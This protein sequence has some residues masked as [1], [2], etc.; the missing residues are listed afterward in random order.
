[1]KLT[2]RIKRTVPAVLMM[3]AMSMTSFAGSWQATAEGWK[4]LNDYGTYTANTWMVA[5][6]L[7]YHMN[8]F[9]IMDTGWIQDSADGRLYY[10]DPISGVMAEGWRLIDSRWYFF[11]TRIGGPRGALLTGWQWIDGKCYY[12]DPAQG[13]ACAV[14]VTTPDGYIVD[15]TGAWTDASGNQYFE[16]G[17]GISST[18]RERIYSET[19]ETEDDPWFGDEDYYGGS[20]GGS[21][22]ASYDSQ[23]EGYDD[24][25]VSGSANNF[26]TGNY[27]MM[28]SSQISEMKSV[29]ADFKAQ[30]ITDDMSDFE[31]ELTIIQWIVENCEYEASESRYD[32]SRS[33]A[34]SVMIEGKGQCAGYA[35]AFLQMAMACGLE[36]RYVYNTSHAW[37][38]VKLDGDWY[39]VDVTW[40]DPIGSNSYGFGS[41]R[42]KYINLTDSEIS[43]EFSSHKTWS[44]K[45][46]KAN[47]TKYGHYTV[48]DYLETGEVDISSENRA[49]EEFNKEIE[50]IRNDEVNNI[51]HF[52]SVDQTVEELAAY[53]RHML[54]DR[55]DVMEAAI[56]FDEFKDL[57]VF[58]S[59]DIY[60]YCDEI[61]ERLSDLM[62]EEYGDVLKSSFDPLITRKDM[63]DNT[64]CWV[65]E[66]VSYNKGEGAEVPYVINFIDKD[67]G[68]VVGT[69][70]GSGE[71][72]TDIAYDFPEGYDWI[73]NRSH[74]LKEGNAWNNGKSFNI[75]GYGR[76]EMDVKVR[77]TAD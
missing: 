14:S 12:L 63:Y 2:N 74:E 15:A 47:G 44:P 26:T 19:E 73:S 67:T 8:A 61:G 59:V 43:S 35:D 17:K 7:D 20:Y 18:T 25:S 57:N 27:G 64:F 16:A 34:Y 45:T 1:M 22:Q 58:D 76:V 28:T 36:A 24:S 54:D 40:E 51:I 48:A 49:E 77:N 56:I 13:G 39:H 6:G 71:R 62:N 3:G 66:S 37:N 10:L 52:E 68:E 11:D 30:Y 60:E 70:S 33:T 42:N 75:R 41:L 72:L 65:Y 53:M 69:Q 5:G 32:W 31:K 23:W 21:Y 50:S 4:Y 46:I 29:I 9:G 55:R 38:L